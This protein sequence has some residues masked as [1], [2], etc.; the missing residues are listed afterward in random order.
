[1]KDTGLLIVCTKDG[2]MFAELL[3]KSRVDEIDKD[4]EIIL[5]CRF[6]QNE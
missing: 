5:K 4:A 1:M 6:I 2:K 3:N